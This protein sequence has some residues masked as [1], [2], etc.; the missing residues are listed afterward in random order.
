[1]SGRKTTYVNVE[2]SAWQQAQQAA[3]RLRD[4]QA[5][6]PRLLEGVREQTRRDTEQATRVVEQRQRTVEQAVDRLG[7]ENRRIE[8]ETN[9][10]LAEQTRQLRGEIDQAVGDLRVD[11]AAALAGQERRLRSAVAD[12][13]RRREQDVAELRAGIAELTAD[14]DRA[15]DA[16]RSWVADGRVLA[17]II[18]TQLPHERFAPGRLAVCERDLRTAEA[19]LAGGFG[20]AALAEAQRTVHA[21]SQLRVDVEWADREWQ[22]V[23]Q[24]AR[25]SLLVARVRIDEVATATAFAADGTELTDSPLNVDHWSGGALSSLA[26]EIDLEL[27]G[28]GDRSTD[29]LRALVDE[30]APQLRNRVEDV[31][32]Q[33]RLAQLGAQLRLNMADVAVELLTGAGFELVDHTYAGDDQRSA[34][35]AKVVHPDGSEVVVDVS[36]AQGDPAAAELS[37]LTYDEVGADEIRQTRAQELAVALREHGL[38]VGA[39]TADPVAPDERFRDFP[40]LRRATAP[41][42]AEGR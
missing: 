7:Q 24:A 22:L 35:Y 19:T 42:P 4:V 30:R 14:K 23:R 39:P 32:D 10:Q 29:E 41:P 6:L 13:R 15:V 34:F 12:E 1:M 17:E 38:A 25:E 11:T 16:A 20:E 27:A 2:Q 31:L 8:R 9:R 28:L 21:L 33:A 18:R 37:I 36:P 5:D 3:R 26:A 40:A